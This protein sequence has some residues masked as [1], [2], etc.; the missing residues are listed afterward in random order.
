MSVVSPHLAPGAAPAARAPAASAPGGWLELLS[1]HLVVALVAL[2]A[3]GGATRVMEAGLACPDW[4]LCYGVLLPGRQMNL[5]VFLEWFHR[6]DA[7]LVGLGLLALAAVSLLQ[8]HR[9]PAWL[10]WAS[11]AA[12]LL[13]A[14]QGGLGALTVLQLLPATVVTAHLATALLLVA[15]L[16][17][18]DQRL[19]LVQLAA[20][21]PAASAPLARPWLL[22][23]GLATALVFGQCVLGGLMASRWA[24]ELCL[25]AGEGCR[26]LLRHRIGAWPA[27]AAVLALLPASL[28]GLPGPARPGL[29]LLAA[30]AALL[31]LLQLA[32]G[33]ATLRLQLSQPA[34]TVGH[35]LTAALLLAVLAA[36]AGRSLP[37]AP[38]PTLEPAHG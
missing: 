15:L 4:P 9:R 20:R 8:R 7:F 34:L 12:L 22:L 5:Q 18:I 13:V 32:L 35:Q 28:V 27:A 21:L 37:V 33:L 6:L 25:Q 3:V 24:A 36:L 2:V 30:L 14:F 17:A 11:L 16:A 10:P 31:V 29:R 26:W 38:V 23:V 1:G 19:R